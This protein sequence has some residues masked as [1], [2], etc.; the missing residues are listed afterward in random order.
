MFELYRVLLVIHI[1][2][3]A[4]ALGG[5][6]GLLRHLRGA[7]AVNVQAFQLATEDTVRRTKLMFLS[8]LVILATGLALIF[9]RGGFGAVPV[10]IHIALLIMLVW[11]AV[12]ASLLRPTVAQLAELG[13]ASQL[14][15]QAIGKKFK[16][17]AM[18]QGILHGCWLIMLVLMIYRGA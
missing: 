4:L 12:S 14:D 8:G 18:S 15:S 16:R 7:L 13:R 3:A 9:V 5:S 17:L 2:A 10:Q 11:I 6:A 1:S